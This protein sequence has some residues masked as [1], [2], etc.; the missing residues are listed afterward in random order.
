MSYLLIDSRELAK[1]KEA[2]EKARQRR[3]EY[4]RR[5]AEIRKSRDKWKRLARQAGAKLETRGS[6]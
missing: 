4:E 1:L 6:T 2:I 5:L 3:Y